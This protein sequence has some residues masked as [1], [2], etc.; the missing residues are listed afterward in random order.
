[1]AEK[2]GAVV[3]GQ[4]GDGTMGCM[5]MLFGPA[6]S[7]PSVSGLPRGEVL[8]S[9]PTYKEARNV[10]DQ[11]AEQEF[12]VR[13]VS[14]VGT[15]LRTVERIRNR[16]TY[17]SVALRSAVQGAFFGLMI[18]ILLSLIDPDASG[19]QVLYTVGLG[20][21]VWVLFG[22][23]GHAM[24]KG[25]GV[26]SVQQLVPTN[27]DVV[28]EFES[29]R[30]AKQLLGKAA[31]SAPTVQQT[32]QPAPRPEEPERPEQAQQPA[33]QPTQQPTQQHPVLTSPQ[34]SSYADLPDG[35]PQY[36]IRLPEHEAKALQERILRENSAQPA[37]A[38]SATG[39][40][41]APAYGKGGPREGTVSGHT[42]AEPGQP[43]QSAQSAD[44]ASDDHGKKDDHSEN[45]ADQYERPRYG[46][47]DITAEP[48]DTSAT[49]SETEPDAGP[50]AGRQA[51]PRD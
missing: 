19:F 46:R 28:C 50:D 30:Q 20:V 6:T 48:E 18:G 51:G 42:P 26:S 9:Y 1:M 21:A 39:S 45:Q 37:A 13:T 10:V 44:E 2:P 49:S 36:G 31:G 5:S 7:D 24:R 25:R 32:Q 40:F 23:I 14:V 12:D 22:V 43:G 38:S 35:R 41:A 29:A 27:F 4:A 33:P 16:L 15:D 47:R 17:P 11:L 34:D 8:G 3:T